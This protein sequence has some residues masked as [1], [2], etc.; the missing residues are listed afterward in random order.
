MANEYY[1]TLYSID[2][3]LQVNQ[4][5]I[6]ISPGDIVSFLIDNDYDGKT[7]P[8]VR[9]RLYSDLTVIQK[10]AEN[11][12]DLYINAAITGGIY[13][14]STDSTP[15][16]IKPTKGFSFF[17]KVY[18]EYKNI[19]TSTMDQYV[20]G[21]PRSADQDLNT[22]NKVPIELYCYDATLIHRMKDQPQ[23]VYKNMT[24]ETITRSMLNFCGISDNTIIMDSFHNSTKYDQVLIPNLN[25]IEALSFFD[26]TFGTYQCGG[27]VYGDF[28]NLY[29]S[30]LA[31]RNG[32][33][34]IPIYVDSYQNNSDMGGMKKIENQYFLN[35]KYDNVS[36]ISESDIA[37][38]LN[39][40]I[41]NAINII[42]GKQDEQFTFDNSFVATDIIRTTAKYL[43]DEY[44]RGNTQILEYNTRMNVLVEALRGKGFISDDYVLHKFSN[45]FVASNIIARL[46]E[47]VT[48][49]DVSGVGFDITQF[50][51]R[52]RFNLIFESPIRGIKM[53]DVYRPSFVVNAFESIGSNLFCATTTMRLC[54]N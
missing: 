54:K 29:I 50:N 28:N 17:M 24:I 23:S 2:F 30:N 48:K 46:N 42:T 11:P 19:P 49:V 14:M 12:D 32:T 38:V 5:T 26:V 36:V 20:N 15:V 6:Q 21:L 18:L 8:I 45:P 44:N 43:T 37:K 51:P 27:S 25:M 4:E 47:Q 40:E 52:T 10:I 3:R 7:Y 41:I 16:M 9:L 34:P 1:S 33:T 53:A 35:T 31:A 22:E 39:S 13:E